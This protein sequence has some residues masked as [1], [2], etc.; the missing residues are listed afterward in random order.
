MDL[1]HDGVI[2][3][4]ELDT[5]L[6]RYDPALEKDFSKFVFRIS[7]FNHNGVLECKELLSARIYR[8]AV[9]KIDRLDKLFRIMD[10]DS[11][12]IIDAHEIQ[13]VLETCSSSDN[14]S[15]SHKSI[16]YCRELIKEIDTDCDGKVSYE[17]FLDIFDVRTERKLSWCVSESRVVQE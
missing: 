6:K 16:A 13:S 1:N 5:M 14:S 4:D 11:N 10:T 3:L 17:E 12:G 7:D 8:K 2:Q 9:S 15:R